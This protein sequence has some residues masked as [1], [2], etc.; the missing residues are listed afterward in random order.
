MSTTHTSTGPQIAN[1]LRQPKVDVP[2][3]ARHHRQPE[4]N[5]YV[6]TEPQL[7]KHYRHVPNLVNPN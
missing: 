6:I 3:P 1:R 7:P 5:I 2:N 4:V